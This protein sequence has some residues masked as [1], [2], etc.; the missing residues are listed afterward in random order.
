MPYTSKLASSNVQTLLALRREVDSMDDPILN[1]PYAQYTTVF[2]LALK[3]EARGRHRTSGLVQAFADFAVK[4]LQPGRPVFSHCE[5]VLP[6]AGKPGI[7]ASYYRFE[8]TS[9]ASWQRPRK[10]EHPYYISENA[11]NWHALPVR[12]TVEQ[13]KAM[14]DAANDTVGT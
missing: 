10:W 5:L 14:Q 4:K 3:P 8:G 2:F 13:A 12:V 1:T 7:Y 6:L 11:S 9:G